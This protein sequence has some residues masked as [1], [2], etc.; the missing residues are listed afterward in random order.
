MKTKQKRKYRKI[1]ESQHNCCL[2]PGIHIHHIDGDRSNND[3]SNL[4]AVT[5]Q[6]HYDIHFS[7]GDYYAAFQLGRLLKDTPESWL[8]AAKQNGKKIGK[9]MWAE[10]IGLRKWIEENP[11][12]VT[13][14]AQENGKKGS[15]TCKKL[16]IGLFGLNSEQ[17]IEIAK[18][19]GRAS[20]EMGLGFKLGHAS[21]AGKKGGIKGA[22]VAMKNKVGI[23][24]L[25]KEQNLVRIYNSQATKAIKSGKA[26]AWPRSY[27]SEIIK[28]SI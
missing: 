14:M 10:G 21:E 11:E 9:K 23:F 13:K 26:S 8:E 4:K 18:K 3:P 20:S 16:S 19:G 7:Q 27:E 12:L 28:D 25:S 2:L 17:R 6:E 1:Y 5:I 15:E 24:N 22:A